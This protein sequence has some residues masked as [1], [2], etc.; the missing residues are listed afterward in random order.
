MS[1]G[2]QVDISIDYHKGRA[3][4]AP[5]SPSP[6][7][8]VDISNRPSQGRLLKEAATGG[9]M[10]PSRYFQST[11]TRPLSM[12]ILPN[13][14]K[15]SKST[16]QSTITSSN[17]RS[18]APFSARVSK[19]TFPNDHHK[20]GKTEKSIRVRVVSKSTLTIDVRKP[21]DDD[22]SRGSKS[23]FQVDIQSTFASP[24][25]TF[26]AK[27]GIMFTSRHSIDHHKVPASCV[28]LVAGFPSRHFQST[29]TSR[30]GSSSS[31]TEQTSFQVDIS[32]RPSQGDRRRAQRPRTD[33]FQVDISNRPSQAAPL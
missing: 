18:Q 6:G 22:P 25:P 2:F 14:N 10:F 16:F 33:G 15:V 3:D 19:S 1:G 7:F 31:I 23:S 30:A 12:H 26:T 28:G 9:S 20:P 11:I 24:P 27:S 8:Q 17:R 4:A 13:S 29:I 32:N 5:G 21:H